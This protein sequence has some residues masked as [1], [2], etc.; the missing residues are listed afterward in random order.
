MFDAVFP[1]PVEVFQLDLKPG[2]LLVYIYLQYQKDVRSGQ[3]WPSYATIG[4]AV[5]MS[6]K[7]VQKHIEIGR[8]SCRERVCLS[9]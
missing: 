8:A 5:G 3:C 1:V 9:V 2:E 4:V 6:R 7:T